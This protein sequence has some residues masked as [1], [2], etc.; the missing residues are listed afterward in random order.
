MDTIKLKQLSYI[1]FLLALAIGCQTVKYPNFTQT[2]TST[3]GMVS[4]GQPLATLAGTQ[5]LEQGGNAVDAA[6]ASAFALAVV[7]PSMNGIGGRMQAI[8]RLPNGDIHGIDGTTQAPMRYDTATSPP[9]RYGYGVIG[10][11]GVVAGLTKL[12]EEHGSLPLEVVMKPAI[13]YAKKGFPILKGEARRQASA[14]KLLREFEGSRQYFLKDG[15]TYQAGEKWVQ[16]DMGNTLELIAKGGRDAFYKGEIAR[17]IVADF[18]ANGGL[19]TMEDLANYEAKSSKVLHGTYRG[20]DIHGLWMP[21]FGAITIEI[22]NILENLPMANLQN[23]D[24]ASVVAQAIDLA[25]QD[26]QKQRIPQTDSILNVLTSKSYAATL[27]NKIAINGSTETGYLEQDLPES[28]TAEMGHTTHLSVADENGMMVALT[29]TIGPNMGSKVATPGLGFLYAVTLGPYLGVYKAGERSASHV[30]P[31]IITKD[32][33][34]FMALGAAGGSRIPTAIIAVISRVIDHKMSLPQALAVS[35]VYHDGTLLHIENHEGSGWKSA[36][37]EEL[38]Q[39]GFEIKEVFDK[40][41]FGRVHAVLFD[42]IKQQWIG[43][44]DPDWEG[45]VAGEIN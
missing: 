16:K 17:K 13:K 11:P 6:V 14:K 31:M 22:M 32:G 28:W 3:K 7:E 26:R 33:K 20:Y 27:A 34:P 39:E 36:Y 5:M 40:A 25:Y 38:I 15:R 35:R 44:A 2:G 21:S 18:E 12:L 43:C 8:V 9:V 42:P 29:Q 24:W 4:C 23:A 19:L 10:I 30:S 1:L 41:R 37:S 45:A